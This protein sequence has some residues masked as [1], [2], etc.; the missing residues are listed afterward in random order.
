MQVQKCFTDITSGK[1]RGAA[2]LIRQ[3]LW[4]SLVLQSE[5]AG[6]TN[7]SGYKLECQFKVMYCVSCFLLGTSFCIASEQKQTHFTQLPFKV[8]S[9]ETELNHSWK[10]SAL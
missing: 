7:Q 6:E 4:E 10:A 9:N 3:Q 5:T 1:V 2:L 8:H